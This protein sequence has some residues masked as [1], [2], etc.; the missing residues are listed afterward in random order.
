MAGF[1]V[2]FNSNVRSPSA[3]FIRNAERIPSQRNFGGACL[4]LFET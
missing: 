1:M 2:Q 4:Q 3:Q